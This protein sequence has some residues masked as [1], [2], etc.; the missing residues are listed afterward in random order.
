MEKEMPADET[1]TFY[2][3]CEGFSNLVTEQKIYEFLAG[4][5]IVGDVVILKNEA[6]KQIGEAVVRVGR[7]SDFVKALKKN[8]N[9]SGDDIIR[10]Y[11]SDSDT[12]NNHLVKLGPKDDETNSFI[13]LR[14]L[15]WSATEKDIR[16]LLHDCNVKEVFLTTNDRGKPSGEAFVHLHDCGDASKAMAHNR[17][18][19]R[20]RFVV[21]EEIYESQYLS[22]RESNGAYRREGEATVEYSESSVRLRNLPVSVSD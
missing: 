21:V 3:K 2:I 5:E 1:D 15:V 14:G 17:Q 9:C 7:Q 11:Q 18:Y 6:G 10:V 19:I 8:G 20:E 13:R 16:N 12:Y 22:A 4:C